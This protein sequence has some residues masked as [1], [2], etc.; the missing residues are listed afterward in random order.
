MTYTKEILKFYNGPEELNK[1][2]N[3]LIG[4]LWKTDPECLNQCAGGGSST[5]KKR[6]TKKTKKKNSRK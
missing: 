5:F 6:K 4:D 1:A 2:E 3:V